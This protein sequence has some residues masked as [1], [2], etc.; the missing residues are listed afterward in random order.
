MSKL[1]KF[2][3]YLSKE[4]NIE[5][6]ACL[7]FFCILAFH[8]FIRVIQGTFQVSILTLVEMVLVNYII[9]YIQVLIFHNFDEAEKLGSIEVAGILSCTGIYTI[10]GYIL[11]W[12]GR[13][14]DIIIYFIFFMLFCYVCIY[15]VYK[16]KRRIDSKEL[17]NLL[18]EYK[19]R[20]G[21]DN[22][23]SDQT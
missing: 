18:L 22:G 20:K 2:E 14:V 1:S 13:R 19:K 17:N 4:I 21:E 5:F 10:A 6:K 15:W 8:C 9:C 23:R 7:Y 3:V 11:N 12:F 16:T